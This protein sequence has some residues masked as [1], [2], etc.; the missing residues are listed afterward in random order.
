MKAADTGGVFDVPWGIIWLHSS[1]GPNSGDEWRLL[2]PWTLS[3]WIPTS[4][5]YPS[6]TRPIRSTSVGFVGGCD[7]IAT[8]SKSLPCDDPH[9]WGRGTY[10]TVRDLRIPC[11]RT[12]SGPRAGC[13]RT[14]RVAGDASHSVGVCPS[15]RF[16]T[17]LGVH[18]RI[19]TMY[20]ARVFPFSVQPSPE[21][22]GT[23][24]RRSP[25]VV[26]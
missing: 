24:S 22:L 4:A 21:T 23:P 6:G 9:S 8:E 5:I 2:P 1:P 13:R 17:P 14:R 10:G 12:N 26:A 7:R 15:S 11:L 18:G 25:R 19:E 20:P 16:G 3:R